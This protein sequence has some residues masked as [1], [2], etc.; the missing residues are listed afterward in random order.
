MRPRSSAHC[1]TPSA[2]TAPPESTPTHRSSERTRPRSHR[3]TFGC[4]SQPRPTSTSMGR[5]DRRSASV[6]S[7]I[8]A[9]RVSTRAMTTRRYFCGA[10]RSTQLIDV[11]IPVDGEALVQHET[12]QDIDALGQ[13]PILWTVVARHRRTRSSA[14]T[15]GWCAIDR[16]GRRDRATRLECVAK[17]LACHPHMG[18]LPGADLVVHQEDVQFLSVRRSSTRR[19]RDARGVRGDVFGGRRG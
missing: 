5:T 3:S 9:T 17:P 8:R 15:R 12:G 4:A 14:M 19:S 7:A 18:V 2:A 16:R 6:A 1:C 11:D 10:T 13:P